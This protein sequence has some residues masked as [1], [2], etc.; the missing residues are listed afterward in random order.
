MIALLNQ[1]PV[2]LFMIWALVLTQAM[3]VYVLFQADQE[4]DGVGLRGG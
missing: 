3:D 2:L 4:K 1:F